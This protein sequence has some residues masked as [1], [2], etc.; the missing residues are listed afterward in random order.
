MAYISI[1]YCTIAVMV[2]MQFEV[3]TMVF[4]DRKNGKRLKRKLNML[5]IF[6]SLFWIVIP[7]IWL[8]EAVKEEQERSKRE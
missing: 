3:G 4:E 6:Y 5:K 7:F 1:I 8:L 2:L